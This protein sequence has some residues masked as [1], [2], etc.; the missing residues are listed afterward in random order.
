[1]VLCIRDDVF[2]FS[3]A[4]VSLCLL[5]LL[6]CWSPE[7]AA[8]ASELVMAN[9]CRLTASQLDEFLYRALDKYKRALVEPGEVIFAFP[10]QFCCLG[11][12]VDIF[13]RALYDAVMQRLY[14]HAVLP[15][16]PESIQHERILL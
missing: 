16:P 7:Q 13:A 10:H 1:M 9:T 15:I 11:T 5:W 4:L 6:S 2:G 3:T 14:H 8:E 12:I